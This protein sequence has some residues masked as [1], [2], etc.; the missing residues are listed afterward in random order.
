[1]PPRLTCNSDYGRR[2]GPGQVGFRGGLA[3]RRAPGGLS[4]DSKSFK[5]GKPSVQKAL[6]QGLVLE[7]LSDVISA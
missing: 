4:V 5:K 7:K 1:M 2:C 6:I 3:G